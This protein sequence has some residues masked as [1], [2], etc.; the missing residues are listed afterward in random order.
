MMNMQQCEMVQKH[1]DQFKVL[2][3]IA[4]S[5]NLHPDVAE[6]VIRTFQPEQAFISRVTEQLMH[7]FKRE[8]WDQVLPVLGHGYVRV[9]DVIKQQDPSYAERFHASLP[10]CLQP[11]LAFVNRENNETFAIFFD[12]RMQIPH[13]VVQKINSDGSIVESSWYHHHL[14]A[15]IST[16]EQLTC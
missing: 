7:D 4:E 3:Q 10:I 14:T 8:F 5:L 16:A 6:L 13:Y 11:L 12:Y 9:Q 2:Q 1:F 15:A